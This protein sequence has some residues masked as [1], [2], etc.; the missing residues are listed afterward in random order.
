M[1]AL[2]LM[3]VKPGREFEIIDKLRREIEKYTFKVDN[4]PFIYEITGPYD[5][6][7]GLRLEQIEDV[8]SILSKVREYD[9][10]TETSTSILIT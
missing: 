8:R 10:V 5:V 4:K 7:I 2:I 6:V 3:K 1:L 9:G